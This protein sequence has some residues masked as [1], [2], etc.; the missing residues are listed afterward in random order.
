[1]RDRYE[2][3]IESAPTYRIRRW[4]MRAKPEEYRAVI[5]RCSAHGVSRVG[6]TT[7]A[8]TRIIAYLKARWH[9]SRIRHDERTRRETPIRR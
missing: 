6:T 5:L 3:Y 7:T 2:I 4:T 9:A 8:N 1:M